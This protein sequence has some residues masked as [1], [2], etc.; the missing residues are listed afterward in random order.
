MQ[1]GKRGSEIERDDENFGGVGA[2]RWVVLPGEACAGGGE[3]VS[4]RDN[5]V[6]GRRNPIATDQKMPCLPVAGPGAWTGR[7]GDVFGD[8]AR[9]CGLGWV[10]KSTRKTYAQGWR[11]WVSWR[12]MRGKGNWSGQELDKWE[13]WE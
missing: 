12:M 9:G 10:A 4:R 13:L 7:R 8:F 3:R 1:G 6:E 2:D 5:E 11:M